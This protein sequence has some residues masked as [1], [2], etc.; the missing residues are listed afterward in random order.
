M[1]IK[2]YGLKQEINESL[3]GE[4]PARI[5]TTYKDRYKIISDKGE[6]FA[7]LKRGCYYDNPNSIYPTIGDFVLIEW[8]DSGD[9]M[10][11]RNS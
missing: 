9:S 5:I 11:T 3:N 1:N 7:Q 6:G 8:N 2:D 4:I 10:I